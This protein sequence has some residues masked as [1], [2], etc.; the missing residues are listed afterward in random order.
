ME[1][2]KL[3]YRVLAIV[4]VY[5]MLKFLGG[6]FGQMALY[7]VTLLVTFLHE[8]GHALGG[9]LT[10]GR[11]AG[12]NIAA[13]GSGYTTT[14]GGNR[15]VILMGG[16]LGSAVLGNLLFFIG[17]RQR[18]LTQATLLV[19][20]VLMALVAFFW[21]ESFQSTG[22]LLV[23]AA[24]LAFIAMKTTWDQDVL[25]FLGLAAVLYIIQDFNVGPSSDLAMYEQT[26]GIFPSKIWMYLW[27]ALAGVLFYFNLKNIFRRRI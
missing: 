17:A 20:A 22:L 19:L 5:I 4:L 23:F 10:G 9:I 12:L 8:F 13:D 7:P 2:N 1:R 16:Y 3:I 26:V 25:M 27:L 21:F 18:Q 15:A 14:V 11:V 24:I 6:S